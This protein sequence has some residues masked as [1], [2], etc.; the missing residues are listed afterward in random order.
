M[1]SSLQTSLRVILII[2]AL[3]LSGSVARA[4]DIVWTNEVTNTIQG[5]NAD[6]SG[7]TTLVS[8]GLDAPRSI[9]YYNNALYF[10]DFGHDAIKRADFNG[11]RTAVTGVTTLFS[12]LDTSG[13]SGIALD[14]V[15]NLI[16][17]TRD[18]PLG[19]QAIW[20]AN[21]DGTGTPT[22]V[23]NDSSNPR[24]IALDVAAD[25]MYWLRSDVSEAVM[26]ASLDGAGA[27]TLL[28]TAGSPKN[29]ALDIANSQ[30][31]YT[32]NE[33]SDSLKGVFRLNFDGTGSTKLISI[34]TTGFNAPT[35]IALDV[36][37]SK[38]YIT[39]QG[40]GNILRTNLDGTGIEVLLT[41]GGTSPY[42][43]AVIPEPS[44]YAFVFGL[45]A[46]LFTLLRRHGKSKVLA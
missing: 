41:V 39:D 1:K 10:A 12:G 14:T 13:V 24:G 19:V 30:L 16:Y 23:F 15:N 46:V 27:T 38:L 6:G 35:G 32:N 26:R 11:D 22:F 20:K 33:G 34:P 4:V 3:L 45:C 21:I 25:K 44:T 40:T 7:L 36:A 8:T 37:A 9:A 28:A 29:I 31:Y 18:N 17:Y 42:G 2:A 5:F 43:I